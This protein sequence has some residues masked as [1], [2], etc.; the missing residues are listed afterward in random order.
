MKALILGDLFITNDV[1]KLELENAFADSGITFEYEFRTNE[2][3]VKPVEH[4][5]EIREFVGPDDDI[6]PLAA[7][8]EIIFT[9]SAGVT[10]RVIEAAHK[11]KVIGA[12]RGGPVNINAAACTERGIPV[13]YAPGRNSGAVAE[14]TVGMILAATRNI[15]LAH[16]SLTRERRWRGDLYVHE[17]VGP[18][19][20]SSV[21]GLIGFGAIGRKVAF[22]LKAFGARI[23][24]YDPYASP[25]QMASL[26]VEIAD[27]DDV[28]KHSDII[29]MHARLSPESEEMIGAREINLMKPSAYLV[30]TARGELIDHG[31]LY[32]ALGEKRI[33]GAALD[34]FEAEPPPEES[35]IYGL[36]NVVATTHLGG[37]SKQ[38]A[39]IGAN[40]AA[41]EIY[42]IITGTDGPDYCVNP[43]VFES[44]DK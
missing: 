17:K 36:D 24:A 13:V 25:T 23:M 30:N 22:I 29:S 39:K 11:L 8:A 37:A 3:P 20:N 33:A 41:V 32:D 40:I 19:L 42:K 34:V 7:D 38:A 14:F 2:W 18:E 31:A 1:L 28:L 27:L 9:H 15:P 4:N 21:V 44:T 5:N 26:E 6:V 35:P 12:A 16:G 10:R 43:V